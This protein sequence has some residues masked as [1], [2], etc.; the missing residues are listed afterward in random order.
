M[1][2]GIS[3]VF[4]RNNITFSMLAMVFD[5]ILLVPNSDFEY[6]CGERDAGYSFP[7]MDMDMDIYSIV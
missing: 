2:K 5:C 3:R 6:S 7:H 4:R 1:S